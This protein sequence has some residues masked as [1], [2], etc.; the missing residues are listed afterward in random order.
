MTTPEDIIQ[1]PRL[2]SEP[3]P[4]QGAFQIW[5][6][7]KDIPTD[8]D[9]EVGMQILQAQIDVH[10]RRYPDQVIVAEKIYSFEL[11][12]GV[13]RLEW[14]CVIDLLADKGANFSLQ[15]EPRPVLPG[16]K[17]GVFTDKQP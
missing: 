3:S 8:A 11:D 7:H 9:R 6:V 10:K 1:L 2:Q 15:G 14:E 4:T 17:T 5:G 12:D 16:M 13:V